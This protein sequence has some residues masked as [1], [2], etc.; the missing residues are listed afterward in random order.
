MQKATVF[1]LSINHFDL[2]VGE[3][4]EQVIRVEADFFQQHFAP[5]P[6]MSE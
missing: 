5:E 2:Y 1:G 4:F 6:V 3:V